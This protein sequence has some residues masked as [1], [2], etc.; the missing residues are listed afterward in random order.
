MYFILMRDVQYEV[1][2]PVLIDQVIN[3]NAHIT[4]FLAC[5]KLSATGALTF[6]SSSSIT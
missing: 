6:S 3:D 5:F 1:K 4:S 2:Q